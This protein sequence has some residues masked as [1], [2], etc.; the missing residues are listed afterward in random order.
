MEAEIW[1]QSISFGILSPGLRILC[2]SPFLSA[3]KFE[4]SHALQFLWESKSPS[5][6]CGCRDKKEFPCER[7]DKYLKRH[8]EFGKY[9]SFVMRSPLWFQHSSGCQNC[10]WCPMPRGIPCSFRFPAE[11]EAGEKRVKGRA[12]TQARAKRYSV[13]PPKQFVSRLK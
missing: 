4:V 7:D 1:I 13:I 8:I 2:Q 6:C 11:K 5:C 9:N 12:F 10:F 3:N